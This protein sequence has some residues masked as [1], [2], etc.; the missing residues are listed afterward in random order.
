MKGL[1]LSGGKGT[2]LRPLTYT[3]AKQLVPLANKP[4]LFYVLEDLVAAGITEIGIVVGDTAQQIE[5]AVGDGSAFG[6]RVTYIQQDTPA[7]LAHAVKIS[8]EFI[9]D[10]RFVMYLGDN[11]IQGGIRPFVEEFAASTANASVLLYRV[12][13][14]SQFGVAELENGRI[15]RLEEKPKIPRSDLALVGIYLFDAHI[16]EAVDHINPSWRGELEITDAISWLIDH[17]YEV[18]PHILTGWWIDTGKMED[19][20]DANRLVLQDIRRDLRGHIA[21]DCIIQGNVVVAEGAVVVNSTLRGP[22]IIG[23][24]SSVEDS[25]IGPFTAIGANCFIKESEIEHSIVMDHTR[26]IGIPHRIEDSLIGRNVELTRSPIKPRA[27]KMMLGDH[28][29]VGIL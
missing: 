4:V 1:V 29:K 24:G 3:G 19:M 18:Q 10:A 26:I 8:R 11:F 5:A 28:S 2:R 14:P 25:Y 27:Y 20:L 22:L 7:G 15:I 17:G 21:E 12:P 16:F 23:A 9:G 13:N 6:A